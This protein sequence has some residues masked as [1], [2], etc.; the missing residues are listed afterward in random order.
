L[1]RDLELAASLTQAAAIIAYLR[2]ETEE[3][4]IKLGRR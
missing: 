4:A 3:R 1:R 2:Q